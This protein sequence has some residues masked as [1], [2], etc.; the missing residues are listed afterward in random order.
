[1]ISFQFVKSPFFYS[2]SADLFFF[3]LHLSIKLDGWDDPN[4]KNANDALIDRSMLWFFYIYIYVFGPP[5]DEDLRVQ[6][7]HVDHD[8]YSGGDAD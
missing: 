4:Y 1:V 7:D 8:V 3:F 2:S 5:V 6:A